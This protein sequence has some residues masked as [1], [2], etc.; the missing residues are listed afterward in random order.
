[1][2]KEHYFKVGDVDDMAV[3]IDRHLDNPSRVTYDMSLYDWDVIAR[4]TKAV[5]DSLLS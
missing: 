1:M 2:G 3:N 5:Y 4:E